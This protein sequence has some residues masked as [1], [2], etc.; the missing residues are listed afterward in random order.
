[1]RH[2]KHRNY[3]NSFANRG[4]GLEEDLK[5][6]NQFYLEKNK[7]VIHKKPTAV[8][9]KKVTYPNQK[10]TKIVDGYF[11]T[12]STTDYNGI[13][14]RRHLDFEAKE[15][16]SKTNFPLSSVPKHQIEHLK[17][18]N[19]HGGI[20]FLIIRF[21]SLEKTFF[22]DITD[23]LSFLKTQTRKSLPYSFIQEKGVEI[24]VEYQPRLDYLKIIDKLY[25]K[26]VD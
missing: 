22:I 15:T 14:R 16:K 7:A 17:N 5:I 25:F 11:T 23:I 26:G 13:Y 19:E 20:A 4:M 24:P 12:P 1:M 8:T 10:Y 18:I 9:I 3:Q 6:T 2:S 21:V